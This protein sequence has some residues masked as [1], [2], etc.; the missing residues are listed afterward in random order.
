[1]PSSC[2]SYGG[3]TLCEDKKYVLRIPQKSNRMLRVENVSNRTILI[4]NSTPDPAP[5]NVIEYM[6][7]VFQVKHSSPGKFKL[8]WAL[9]NDSKPWLCEKGGT[10]KEESRFEAACTET[11]ATEFGAVPADGG[12]F[13]LFTGT[14]PVVFHDIKN[15][16]GGRLKVERRCAIDEQSGISC[17]QYTLGDNMWKIKPEEEKPVTCNIL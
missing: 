16:W 13:T 1:M 11:N 15:G 12:S 2:K 7:Y 3:V 6:Y 10:A 5:E 4:K 8:K 17:G 14:F 9:E